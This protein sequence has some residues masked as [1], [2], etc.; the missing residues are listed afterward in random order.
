MS[1]DRKVAILA[2]GLKAGGKD[3]YALKQQL[4]SLAN[5]LK[6]NK[7]DGAL[8]EAVLEEV[9]ASGI[10]NASQTLQFLKK[11][12]VIETKIDPAMQSMFAAALK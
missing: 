12:G 4:G 8:A 11:Q 6:V 5:I 2:A 3:G 9:E 7:V 1:N 10:M